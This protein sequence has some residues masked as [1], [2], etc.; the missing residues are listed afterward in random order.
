M[1]DIRQLL[2]D[3]DT[4]HRAEINALRSM[5][6]TRISELNKSATNLVALQA[7]IDAETELLAISIESATQRYISADSRIRKENKLG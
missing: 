1:T 4:I 6:I 2:A 5:A 3:N 7:A